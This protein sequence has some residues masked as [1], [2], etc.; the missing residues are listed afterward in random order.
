MGNHFERLFK[1]KKGDDDQNDKW[2][3]TKKNTSNW[4]SIFFLYVNVCASV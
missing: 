4:L 3:R 2:P 1:K